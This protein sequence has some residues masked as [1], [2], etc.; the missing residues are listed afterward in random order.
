MKNSI[1]AILLI[2]FFSSCSKDDNTIKTDGA[3][4]IPNRNIYVTETMEDS[5]KTVYTFSNFWKIL[6][7]QTYQNE[8]PFEKTTY[9][10]SGLV[11]TKTSSKNN[12][13][14]KYYLNKKGY[15]DSLNILKIGYLNIMEKYTYDNLGFVIKKLEVGQ[16]INVPY[17]VETNYIYQNSNLIKSEQKNDNGTFTIEYEYYLDSTNVMAGTIEATTFLPQSKNLIKKETTSDDTFKLYTYSIDN[18]GNW[19]TTITN[20]L[21][22][23]N[24][25]TS[26]LFY[27]K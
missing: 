10:T 1:F 25:K 4:F 27:I 22:E 19:L 24:Q 15:A 14:Y 21:E 18:E 17:Y 7:I 12:Y 8:T 16:I 2:S 11:I 13:I 20:E 23:V 26:K 3:P 6:E 5:L 9:N